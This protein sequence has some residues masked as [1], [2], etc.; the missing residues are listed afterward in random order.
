MTNWKAQAWY[1]AKRSAS[2]GAHT[3]MAGAL[4]QSPGNS[5][6]LAPFAPMLHDGKWWIA[7]NPD[8][9][10]LDGDILLVNGMDGT[11]CYM[12][13]DGCGFY[14]ATAQHDRPLRLYTNGITFARDWAALRGEIYAQAGAVRLHNLGTLDAPHMPGLVIVGDVAAM[15]DF[16]DI[17]GA[18]SV[19]IDNPR[20][21]MA[22]TDALLRAARLPVVTVM[23]PKLRAVA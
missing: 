23:Q 8:P 11:P 4:R 19:Q 16:A 9:D 18:P 22:L 3:G 14:G 21:R 2:F 17:A 13:D 7:C 12:A 15:T 6:E 20:T 1:A 10:S 5:Y